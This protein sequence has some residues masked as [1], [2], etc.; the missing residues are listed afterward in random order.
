[1]A[2]APVPPID[3]TPYGLA[4]GHATDRV[5]RTGCTVVRGT[6]GPFRCASHLLGRASGTREL[7]VTTPDHLVD[8]VDALLLTGGS[9]HGLDAAAGVMRWLE[10]RGR[11]Y[12]VGVGVVPI[13]PAAVVFDL[14]VGRADVRPTPEMAHAACDTATPRV[15]AHGAVG[16]GTGC[17]VGKARGPALAAPGG[18]GAAEAAVLVGGAGAGTVRCAALAVVNAYGAVRDAAGRVVAGPPDDER[19][20]AMPEAATDTAATPVSPFGNTTLAVVATTTPLDRVA[21]A[22]LARAASAALYRRITPVGTTFDGDVVFAVCPVAP[23]PALEPA[24]TLA[25]ER[26]AVLALEAAIERAV[27]HAAPD[28][29]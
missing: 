19:P 11:G 16:A 12:P 24:A 20:D 18:F 28:G 4:V 17:T 1:M 26:A 5:A 14:G 8:R 9:A 27:R 23:V 21:L 29:V 10:A 25:L 3:L 2:T 13:V 15:M 6:D 22:Q 7:A